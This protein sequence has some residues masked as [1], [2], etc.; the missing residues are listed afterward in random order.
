MAAIALTTPHLSQAADLRETPAAAFPALPLNPKWPPEQAALARLYNRIG[1]LFQ[2]LAE[3]L[4]VPVAAA[5]GVFFVESSGVALQLNRALLRF[6]VHYFWDNWGHRHPPDFEAQ[7]RFGGHAGVAG[8]P[9]QNQAARASPGGAFAPVHDGHQASEYAA[10]YRATQLAGLETAARC[11]S[12]GGC[13]LMGA[14]FALLGYPTAEAMYAA[15][16]SSESAHVLGFF[17]FCE[18]QPAPRPG[19]LIAAL[20]RLDFAAFARH[21]NGGG[22]VEDYARRLAAATTNARLVLTAG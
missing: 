18:R 9:W 22:Q 13:Q 4:D 17:D 15:F 20:R 8:Q 21:Y 2:R 16:Q 6:E 14:N 3:R 10:F 12:L 1:G 11:A 19:G 7:F 5:L